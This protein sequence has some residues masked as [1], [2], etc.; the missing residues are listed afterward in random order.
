MS[1]LPTQ[2][3]Q[4]SVPLTQTAPGK[5]PD[6]MNVNWYLW[7]YN[8]SQAV[9]GNGSSGSTPASPYDVLD[10]A[11]LLSATA[12]IPQAYRAIS[13]VRALLGVGQLVDPMPRAQPAQTV[14]VGASPFT[15]TASRWR[16]ESDRRVRA[17]SRR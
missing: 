7:A 16:R 11:N 8:I 15:Y 12:D 14:T 9:L 4:Q 2:I 10:T 6:Y 5:K 13:N 3:P 17:Q 1:G